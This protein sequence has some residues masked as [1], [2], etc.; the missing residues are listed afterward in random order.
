MIST[1]PG[2]HFFKFSLG[3]DRRVSWRTFQSSSW[4]HCHGNRMKLLP[5]GSFPDDIAWW[6]KIWWSAF[7]IPSFLME[8]PQNPNIWLKYNPESWWSLHHVE[9]HWCTS[10]L[11]SCVYIDDKQNLYMTNYTSLVLNLFVFWHNFLSFLKLFK[12]THIMLCYGK[13]SPNSALLVQKYFFFKKKYYLIL[14][15]MFY[16]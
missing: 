5:V 1:Q 9:T 16:H 13:L 11:T 6:I 2:L 8:D 7:I 14:V 12:G 10:L 15:N 3:I 4:D